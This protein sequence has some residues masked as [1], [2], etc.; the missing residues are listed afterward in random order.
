MQLVK[1]SY[2]P[3]TELGL[4]ALIGAALLIC[5]MYYTTFVSA[6]RTTAE[7]QRRTKIQI[8]EEDRLFCEVF[9]FHS[10]TPLRERCESELGFIRAKQGARTYNVEYGLP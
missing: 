1:S 8:Q 2:R 9:G 7:V 4:L 6:P 10:G 3:R 5:V